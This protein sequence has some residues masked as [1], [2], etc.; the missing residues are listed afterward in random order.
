MPAVT[1]PGAVVRAMLFAYRRTLEKTMAKARSMQ[2]VVDDARFEWLETPDQAIAW[3]VALGLQDEVEQVL[4]RTLEDVR[5]SRAI[6]SAYVPAWY[7][8]AAGGDGPGTGGGG[9]SGL[10]SSSALPNFGGLIGALGTIGNAP[11]S[12]GSG[13]GFGGGGSGGGGGGAGGGF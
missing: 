1:L 11:G 12:S 4:E 9:P 2:Q 7:H 5:G 3:G 10:M 6:G 8:A 13:G